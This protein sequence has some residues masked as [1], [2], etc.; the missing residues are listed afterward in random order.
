MLNHLIN[1]AKQKG[2]VSRPGFKAK[3]VRW[4]IQFDAHG[5]YLGPIELGDAGQRGNK[6]RTFSMCPDL[7]QG[8]LVGGGGRRHFLVDSAEVVAEERGKLELV[9]AELAE[10]G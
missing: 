3:E 9:L 5:K 2:L 10:L 7:T 4:A 6:G 8:E 1:Y